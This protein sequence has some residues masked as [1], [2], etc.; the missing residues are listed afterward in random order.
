VCGEAAADPALAP[1]LVGL[2]M[3]TLS[4]GPGALA[5]VGAALER[6]TLADCRAQA[7]AACA[8]S[9]PRAARVAVDD[10]PFA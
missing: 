9:G 6:L 8:A 4:M 2:G 7:A 5:A 1:V 3:A 10:H